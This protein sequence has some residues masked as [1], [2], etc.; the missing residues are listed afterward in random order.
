MTFFLMVMTPTSV[1]A[2]KFS[3]LSGKIDREKKELE[4]LK[5]EI[6]EKRDKS[7][8]IKKREGS[9]LSQ[10]EAMDHRLRLLRKDAESI[11]E[12]VREKDAEITFLSGEISE[13]NRE[14]GEKKGTVS[15]RVRTLYQERQVGSLKTLSAARDYP[16][17]MRRLYYLNR[18]AGREG[19]MLSR[20]KK[21]Q[22][23]LEE[24]SRQLEQVKN[25]LISDKTAL[26]RKLVE[27]RSEKKNKDRILVRVRNEKSFYE[28]ALAELDESSL[29]LQ[30][31][32]KKMEEEKKR[33][34]RPSS[35]KFSKEKGQLS[36]PNDGKIVSSFGKQKHPK[37]DTFIYKKGI[38]IEPSRG[39][40][41]R[42]VF[43]GIV[44][45][46]DWFRG[47]GMV[48]IVDH[49]ENYYSVYAHLA[50]LLVSVGDRVAKEMPIGQVGETG[51]SQGSNL[52]FEI[53]HQG[54]PLDPL[55]WL[56]KR[57]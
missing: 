38:E 7:I 52:Y 35:E 30:M 21:R 27:I 14:I 17:F 26:A 32:I 3:T 42:S 56:P 18:I 13:L 53:R 20:F 23:E 6:Q 24:K 10:L 4:K 49:G 12:K 11:E 34:Q 43:D 33:L 28:K 47:Y 16:D 46:A 5:Q 15:K 54:E 36:W 51:L 41:V 48:I 19:E 45:F 39:D 8:S 31:M 29:Q 55:A 57:R 37:F 40:N 25:N 2:E 50:K 1:V 9:V 44:T 22:V